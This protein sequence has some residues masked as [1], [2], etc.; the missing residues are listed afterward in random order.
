LAKRIDIAFDQCKELAK[1]GLWCQAQVLFH[2]TQMA[3]LQHQ[4][5]TLDPYEMPLAE[6]PEID[7][8][9]R[10]RLAG[11][12]VFFIGQLA[13]V[14]ARQLE[15]LNIGLR[16]RKKLRA[17]CKSYGIGFSARGN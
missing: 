9:V 1:R 12:G 14:N 7:G 17:I 16:T 15:R 10:E 2:S 5:S 11:I 3:C 4:P 8:R 6:H 13:A